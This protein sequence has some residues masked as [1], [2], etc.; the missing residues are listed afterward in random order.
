LKVIVELVTFDNR[1]SFQE[2]YVSNVTSSTITF[3]ALI[4]S[5]DNGAYGQ[6]ASSIALTGIMIMQKIS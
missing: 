4:N 1:N 2:F 5:T 3:N 6:F